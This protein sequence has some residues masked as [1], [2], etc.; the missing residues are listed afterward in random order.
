[1]DA[2][3]SKELIK[4][5]QKMLWDPLLGTLQLQFVP[6]PFHWRKQER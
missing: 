6:A 1:M 4:G 3:I 5:V 2:A